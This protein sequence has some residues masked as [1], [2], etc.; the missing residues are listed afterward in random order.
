M[1]D[2]VYWSFGTSY[3]TYE[4]FVKAVDDYN[5]D[6][7]ES[8]WNAH[9]IVS[10]HKKIK[11]NFEAIWKDEDDFVEVTIEASDPAGIKMGEILYKINQESLKI[12]EGAD[13]TFFEG[14]HEEGE[15]DG[16]PIYDMWTGS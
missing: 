6:M 16:V 14:L 3:D 5:K 7:G 4:N 9:Q 11:V 10:S 8:K 2:Y 12:F 13:A 15:E 1:L